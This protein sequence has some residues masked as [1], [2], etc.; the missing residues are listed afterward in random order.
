MKEKFI[1]GIYNYCDRWCER[2]HFTSRCRNYESTSNLSPEQMDINNEAFWENLSSNF[3]ATLELLQKAAKKYGIDLSKPLTEEE[4]EQYKRSEK[5]LDTKT[6][7]HFL[8]TLCKQYRSIARPFLENRTGVVN[9]IIELVD[10]VHI[11]IKSEAEV[12]NTVAGIG[13][14]FDI[15]QWYVFFIDA[16]LQRALHGKIEGE[17][18]ET[19]NGFQKDSN[20]SAKVALL[21]IERSMGAWTKLYDLLISEEDAILKA[22]SLLA[23]LKETTAKEFPK[24]MQ[25]KRPGF[26]D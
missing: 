2:C 26:D 1:S 15:I 16:K 9:K 10:H 25:F 21:A 17:D 6:K 7:Q 20:G 14:C 3:K 23:Q 8:I 24:A 11:G 12:E 19:E 18:W 4:E 5:L 22:L 13:D